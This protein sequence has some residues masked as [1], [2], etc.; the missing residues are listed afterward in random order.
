[1]IERGLAVGKAAMAASIRAAAPLL[2]MC[3]APPVPRD[4]SPWPRATTPPACA[5]AGLIIHLS[6]VASP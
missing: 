2:R 3:P 4:R 5:A 6:I 1:V